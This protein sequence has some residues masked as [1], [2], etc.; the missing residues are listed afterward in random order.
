MS[1]DLTR[2]TLA[3]AAGT[4]MLAPKAFAQG[5]YPDKPIKVIV[6]FG[7]GGLADITTRVTAERLST[8]IGQ[9]IVVLNQPG[10]N[11]VT[12][13]KAALAAPADGYTV[14]LLANST[15]VAAAM[16]A[17]PAFDAAKEFT[18]ISSLGFFD[19][20][21][22]TAG[23]SP[24]TKLK[25][26]IDAA[27]ATPDKLNIGTINVGSSQN[28]SAVLF[29]SLA[30]ID[31]SIVPFRTSPEVLT[32]AIRGDVQLAVEGFASAKGLL[33]DKQVRALASTG[34][35]RSPSLPDVP[36]VAEAGVPGFVVDSWN[37]IF[38]VA[39]TPPAA[40]ALLNRQIGAALAD[41]TVK[42]K[43]ADLGIDARGGPP[44]E[45]GKRLVDDIAKWTDVVTKAGIA[46]N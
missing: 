5:A 13:A 41:P 18:P 21:F 45:I 16:A 39:G 14:I 34:T 4:A 38:A 28:L 43:F 33:A 24:Y 9:Q 22:L 12:A 44:E 7:P 3:I 11:G 42:A 40:I 19:F 2:R 1:L 36:T 17:K 37:A 15:S 8:L 35:K 31:V 6:P 23:S 10:A 32:A 27:K 29:K 30:G 26:F 25:D 46:R 20:Q